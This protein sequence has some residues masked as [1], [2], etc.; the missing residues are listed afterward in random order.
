MSNNQEVKESR[1][2]GK[3]ARI[4]NVEKYYPHIFQVSQG[5]QT[6]ETEIAPLENVVKYAKDLGDVRMLN[7]YKID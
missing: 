6:E 1:I 2:L 3:I 7:Y 4:L 5:I